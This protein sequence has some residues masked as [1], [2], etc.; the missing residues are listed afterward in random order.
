MAAVFLDRRDDRKHRLAR[1]GW[2]V[3]LVAQ[4]RTAVGQRSGFV[5]NHRAAQRNLL[6]RSRVFDD[7]SAFRCR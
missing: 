7:D 3:S 2:R 1:K 6:E 5:Q 4:T